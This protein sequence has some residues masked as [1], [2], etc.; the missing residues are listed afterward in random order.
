MTK[1]IAKK[2]C[3]RIRYDYASRETYS[4]VTRWEAERIHWRCYNQARGQPYTPGNRFGRWDPV[5]PSDP[6]EIPF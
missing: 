3:R 5:L 1:R 6:L 4:P 2:V